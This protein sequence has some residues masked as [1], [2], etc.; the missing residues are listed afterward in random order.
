MSIGGPKTAA[1]GQWA[2]AT[3]HKA[4]GYDNG[5]NATIVSSVS[6]DWRSTTL[7]VFLHKCAAHFGNAD[8]GYD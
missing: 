4:R 6:T 5:L 8:I 1:P 3:Y 7:M 2:C